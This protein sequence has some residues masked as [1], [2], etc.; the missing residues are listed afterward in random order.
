M[1]EMLMHLDIFY[2]ELLGTDDR[3][4]A[5][6]RRKV[7]GQDQSNRSQSQQFEED[8]HEGNEED[9]VENTSMIE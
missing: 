6:W 5:M 4:G 3:W 8:P 7:A 1:P 9:S 2:I